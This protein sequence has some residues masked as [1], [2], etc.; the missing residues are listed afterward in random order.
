MSLVK[1]KEFK[2]YEDAKEE[3]DRLER[4]SKNM[5]AYFVSDKDMN[6]IE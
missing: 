1:D 2:S 5:T 4:S 6:R 3:A